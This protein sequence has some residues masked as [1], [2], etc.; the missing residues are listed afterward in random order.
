MSQV[1]LR[2]PIPVG[3]LV[4]DP[5]RPK[6]RGTVYRPP[7]RDF[8]PPP[9]ETGCTQK[10]RPVLVGVAI[11][12]LLVA[13]VGLMTSALRPVRQSVMETACCSPSDPP[14]AASDFTNL[15][16][17]ESDAVATRIE[18]GEA[19]P[20]VHAPERPALF[21]ITGPEPLRTG[22]DEKLLGGHFGTKL[23]FAR[24]QSVAFDRGVREQKLV[25]VLH[26]AGNFED[27]GFT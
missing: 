4:I 15:P 9:R 14:D 27:P 17:D 3:L 6:F 20:T 24:S 5:H 18:L 1:S 10:R 19:R 8:P 13:C 23:S 2:Q 21:E 22:T 12:M 26:L 11:G 16:D 25:M 7:Q